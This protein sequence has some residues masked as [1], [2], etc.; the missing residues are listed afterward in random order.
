[1]T[2]DTQVGTPLTFTTLS[3]FAMFSP[4]GAQLRLIALLLRLLAQTLPTS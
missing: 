2:F 4:D 1:L 3:A